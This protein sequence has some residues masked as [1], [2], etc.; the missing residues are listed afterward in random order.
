[1][2]VIFVTFA[3]AKK[4]L[5]TQKDF[6]S[7]EKKMQKKK[8]NNMMALSKLWAFQCVSLESVLCGCMLASI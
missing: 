8:D 5:E 7:Y 3:Q 2:S 4:E 1:M 6:T